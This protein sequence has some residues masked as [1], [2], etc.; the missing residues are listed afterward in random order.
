MLFRELSRRYVECQ[1]SWL[2]LAAGSPSAQRSTASEAAASTGAGD[3]VVPEAE[4]SADSSNNAAPTSPRGGHRGY[5][6]VHGFDVCSL[7]LETTFVLLY[8]LFILNT[9]MRSMAIKH[10]MTRE[11]FMRYKEDVLDL[12][13]IPPKFF[14]G[15]YDE[16]ALQGLPLPR[17]PAVSRVCA[18]PTPQ[19]APPSETLAAMRPLWSNRQPSIAETAFTW[20]R[21]AI[22]AA[23]ER[24]PRPSQPSIPLYRV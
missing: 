17:V 1:Q 11:A 8:A 6:D 7:D 4:R 18:A 10:K 2:A 5:H 23:D 9:D 14:G 13:M 19:S 24:F 21:R 20:L 16:L 22:R 15:S 12:R 3:C